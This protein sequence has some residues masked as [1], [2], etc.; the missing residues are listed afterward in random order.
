M[1]GQLKI[2]EMAF[3]IVALVVLFAL[4]ALFFV[5]WRLHSVQGEVE[6]LHEYAGGKIVSQL[7]NTPELGG[8]CHGCLSWDNAWVLAQRNN[9][10]K[11]R[12]NLDYLEI[13]IV[14]VN[15]TCTRQTYPSCGT[16][17]LIPGEAYGTAQRAFG[18]VCYWDQNIE[19]ERC[20]LGM[21]IAS[22]GKA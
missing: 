19:Q 4:V 11:D 13:Q 17:V 1:K 2:Q 9:S 12:W 7:V 15:Q 5:S 18:A 20:Q 3:V 21:V 10:L 22:G 8:S 16:M 6:T 14:G